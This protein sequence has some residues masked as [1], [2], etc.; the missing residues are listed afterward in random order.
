MREPVPQPLSPSRQ[1]AMDRPD[2]TAQAPSRPLRAEALE[3]AEH[4]RLAVSLRQAAQLFVEDF[5]E[6]IRDRLG[7]RFG[8]SRGCK[9]LASPSPGYSRPARDAVRYAT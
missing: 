8:R 6:V 9:S 4:D 5:S 7:R 2:R 1:P 3:Q